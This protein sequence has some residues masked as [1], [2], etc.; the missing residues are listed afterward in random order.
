M[1]PIIA[2]IARKLGI[3]S[4]KV[5]ASLQDLLTQVDTGAAGTRR[6]TIYMDD[7]GIHMI[8]FERIGPKTHS[9]VTRPAISNKD[10]KALV[11]HF[12]FQRIT[13]PEEVGEMITAARTLRKGG[14]KEFLLLDTNG[15]PPLAMRIREDRLVFE[16]ETLGLVPPVLH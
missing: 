1:T 5:L 6:E 8:R 10:Q 11:K 3:D 9:L 13:N 2:D 12:V 14:A 4:P 7:T 16:P 15:G